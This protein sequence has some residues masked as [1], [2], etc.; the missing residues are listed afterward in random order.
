MSGSGKDLVVCCYHTWLCVIIAQL[1]VPQP[2]RQDG[3]KSSSTFIFVVSLT[4]EVD[5]LPIKVS[6]VAQDNKILL[7]LNIIAYSFYGLAVILAKMGKVL[8]NVAV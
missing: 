8:F 3:F 1:L 5:H 6:N 4:C 7:M 2:K